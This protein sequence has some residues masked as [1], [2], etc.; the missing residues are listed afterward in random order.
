[1]SGLVRPYS[2]P[3]RIAVFGFAGYFGLLALATAVQPDSYHSTRDFISGL[4]AMDAAHPAI[5]V[6]GFQVAA[7]VLIAAAYVL[8]RDLRSASARIAVTLMAVSAA[9]M[10]VA[11][12]ARFDCSRNDAAC[13][14]QLETGMSW[15]SHLHGL[16][17][18]VVF[19]PLILS[20]FVLAVALWRS[21]SPYR[22]RLAMLALVTGLAELALTV[23]VEEQLFG[24]VGLSQR[25]DVVLL[26][27]LPVLLAAG[28]WQL[29]GEPV[30]EIEL[31]PALSR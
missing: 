7:I 4:A 12:F 14:A 16:A 20:S 28:R 19:L 23:A 9:A 21:R 2:V 29:T 3:R 10:S 1:M 6:A 17:A 11:G 27:G 8:V 25:L 30:A 24:T 15:H 18:L 22:R 26:L 13:L 5:M 31:V